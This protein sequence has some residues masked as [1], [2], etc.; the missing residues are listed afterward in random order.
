MS[1]DAARPFI[2]SS[3]QEMRG[4]FRTLNKL[5]DF[6]SRQVHRS[7]YPGRDESSRAGEKLAAWRRE[8]CSK[9]CE[10]VSRMPKGSTGWLWARYA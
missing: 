3:W 4:V 5:Y 7:D 6:R 9:L 2:A 8:V 1:A 10:E